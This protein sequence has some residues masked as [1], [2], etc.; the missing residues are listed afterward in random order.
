MKN[1]EVWRDGLSTDDAFIKNKMK[2]PKWT[3]LPFKQV[4]LVIRAF[5][6]GV[7]KYGRDSWKTLRDGEDETMYV[8]ACFRHLTCWRDT[9]EESGLPHLAHVGANALILLWH[10]CNRKSEA[11]SVE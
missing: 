5:E 7:T 4:V 2:K 8:D 6:Y 1:F 11:E 3:L 10:L 9:D